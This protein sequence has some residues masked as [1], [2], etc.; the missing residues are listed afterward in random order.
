[1]KKNCDASKKGLGVV[2]QHHQNN[3]YWKPVL[4]ATRFLSDFETK[5]SIN[6]LKLLAVVWALERFK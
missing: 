4:F 5:F 6:E 1:M 2:L 3:Q